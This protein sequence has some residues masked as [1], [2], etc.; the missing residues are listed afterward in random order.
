MPLQWPEEADRREQLAMAGVPR[1]L[2]V[3]P[4]ATPPAVWGVD[5]DWVSVE[6]PASERDDREMT[7]RRRLE[8]RRGPTTPTAGLVLD[9]D[10]LVRRAG[11]WVALSE[12]ET[13]LVGLLLAAAGRCVS[14]AQLLDAGWPGQE[15]E[16]RAVDGAVRRARAKLR[17][18]GVEI[19][20]ITGVGYLL[21]VG[22]APVP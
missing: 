16:D 7:L 14:R 18:L 12:L 20:G 8:L 10:G 2:L 22:G 17:D 19:H 9:D 13:R 3:S 11:R 4:G 5:E 6:A 21:E 15:R 1:L